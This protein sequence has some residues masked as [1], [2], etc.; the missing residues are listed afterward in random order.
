MAQLGQDCNKNLVA[1]LKLSCRRTPRTV[2]EPP[3]GVRPCD[4]MEGGSHCL[5]CAD[6]CRWLH[7]HDHATNQTY[8]L[9]HYTYGSPQ[10]A[11]GR[12]PSSNEGGSVSVNSICAM[13]PAFFLSLY[14]ILSAF[15]VW[16]MPVM[17]HG[18][19]F[20]CV[21]VISRGHESRFQKMSLVLMF[22][23]F[24]ILSFTL[25]APAL[26]HGTFAAMVLLL[27]I[28]LCAAILQISPWN[29]CLREM[30]SMQRTSYA[31][32]LAQNRIAE[33]GIYNLSVTSPFV[34]AYLCA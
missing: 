13:A 4:V 7:C 28:P 6:R 10:I 24:G 11:M 20:M 31:I 5:Q 12:L 16:C 18:L 34:L 19:Y 3:W 30:L 33:L 29:P 8:N 15:W 27:L 14:K 17:F 23:I 2:S 26:G 32:L 9:C 25:S 21:M 22:L 1:K